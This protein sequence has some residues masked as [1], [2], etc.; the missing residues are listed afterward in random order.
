[1][2]SNS[3]FHKLNVA[4]AE[5]QFSPAT[6]ITNTTQCK[7]YVSQVK[8]P[9]T[10]LHGHNSAIPIQVGYYCRCA[11]SFAIIWPT[12]STFISEIQA[13]HFF[14]YTLYIRES[15]MFQIFKGVLFPIMQ[16]LLLLKVAFQMLK[17]DD[18]NIT[19]LCC[20]EFLP[21]WLFRCPKPIFSTVTFL[22]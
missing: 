2:S 19:K 9:F 1:M 15:S 6:P 3:H 10:I 11:F 18:C 12:R 7:L 21:S 4:S 16:Q 20:F 14:V 22:A 5:Y 13:V 17:L 8:S